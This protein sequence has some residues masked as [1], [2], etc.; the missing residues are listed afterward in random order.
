MQL[1]KISVESY[2]GPGPPLTRSKTCAGFNNCLN[3]LRNFMP[4]LSPDLLFTKTK[5]GLQP[6]GRTASQASSLPI[7][8]NAVGGTTLSFEG[9]NGHVKLIAGRHAVCTV[10]LHHKH[11]QSCNL[12]AN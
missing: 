3:L 4:W 9:P 12:S 6:F 10:V 2:P 8:C 5:S 11:R 7:L 1:K